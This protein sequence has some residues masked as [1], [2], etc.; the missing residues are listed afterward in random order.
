MAKILLVLTLGLVL[1]CGYYLSSFALPTFGMG[2]GFGSLPKMSVSFTALLMIALLVYVAW[3][4]YKRNFMHAVTVVVIGFLILA[5]LGPDRT[6]KVADGI[7]KASNTAVTS[8]INLATTGATKTPLQIAAERKAEVAEIQ[9]QQELMRIKVVEEARTRVAAEEAAARALEESMM[10]ARAVPC[11]RINTDKLGCQTVTFGYN[12]H[13]DRT[14]RYDVAANGKPAKSYC[15]NHDGGDTVTT[16]FLGNNQFR[17]TAPS[18]L[19]VQ[20]FDL[21]EGELYRNIKCG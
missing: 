12:T 7:N 6:Q 13:Y 2:A 10:D 15:I 8:A 5:F 1:L 11:V 21:P 18:G 3:Q 19:V 16:T 17:F 9:R 14:A 4:F 20:F